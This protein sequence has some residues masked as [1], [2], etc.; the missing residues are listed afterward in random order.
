MCNGAVGFVGCR[1]A[2]CLCACVVCVQ[3]YLGLA[4]EKAGKRPPKKK[5]KKYGGDDLPPIPKFKFATELNAETFKSQVVEVANSTDIGKKPAYYPLVMFHVSWCKHCR[6]ALPEVEQAAETI[7]KSLETRNREQLPVPP[8]FFLL[9]CD[10][11][12]VK[13]ICAKYSTTSYPVLKLFRDQREVRFNRPRLAQTI[14]WWST[15][16]SRP[17]IVE[18]T[19]SP[20]ID[21][22]AQ[23]GVTLFVLKA[24]LPKDNAILQDWSEVAFDYLE[25][26]Y[27]FA[28]VRSSSEAAHKFPAAPCVSVQG[29]GLQPLPL[30]GPLNLQ[31][32]AAWVKL[33][34]FAPVEELDPRRAYDLMMSGLPTVTLVYDGTS[35]SSQQKHDFAEKVKLVRPVGKHL[36]ATLNSSAGDNADFLADTF[37]LVSAKWSSLPRV[38]VMDGRDVYFE[39][40]SF[41]IADISA[42]SLNELM[43]SSEARQDSSAMGWLK[44]KRKLTTRYAFSSVSGFLIVLFLGLTI[45]VCPAGCCWMCIVALMEPDGE[46]APAAKSK[47]EE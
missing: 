37:P 27:Y 38:F 31:T 34:R 21:S 13:D 1:A 23:G 32:L 45:T 24:D 16:V 25:E 5:A 17:P 46:E 36:F 7:T 33:N 20:A 2:R 15:H 47:K 4:A 8:K 28:I 6:H 30:Q 29:R 9:R 14:A 11:D 44:G 12:D 22:Y 10:S 39:S 35:A 43:A 18:I 41:N 26:H 3:L 42:A 19:T 40:P